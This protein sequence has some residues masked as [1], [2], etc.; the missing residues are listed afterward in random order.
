MGGFRLP[1]GCD[2]V[3]ECCSRLQRSAEPTVVLPRT[4]AFMGY[5]LWIIVSLTLNL[6]V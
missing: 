5:C 2:D 4:T 1:D 3:E 6:S